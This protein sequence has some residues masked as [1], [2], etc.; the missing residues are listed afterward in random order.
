M[1]ISDL[2]PHRRESGMSSIE[3]AIRDQLT[4]VTV[5]STW[6]ILN[7]VHVQLFVHSGAKQVQSM[8]FSWCFCMFN[9][10]EG[11]VGGGGGVAAESGL[12]VGGGGDLEVLQRGCTEQGEGFAQKRVQTTSNHLCR[13]L[14]NKY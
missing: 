8:H 12:G 10:G 1:L 7:S 5:Y 3:L 14:T 13:K 6:D 9:G 11:G 4:F 2:R